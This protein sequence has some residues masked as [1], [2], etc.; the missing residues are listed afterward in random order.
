M[1]ALKGNVSDKYD[2][3]TG[4][5]DI[6]LPI[7]NEDNDASII[8]VINITMTY[9]KVVDMTTYIKGIIVTIILVAAMIAIVCAFL[10][11]M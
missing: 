7:Y 8:G 3:R 10:Y 9:G 6:S 11:P 2:T 5:A 1:S 4:V